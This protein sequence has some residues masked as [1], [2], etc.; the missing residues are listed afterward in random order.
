M[1]AQNYR[2]STDCKELIGYFLRYARIKLNKMTEYLT[3][4]EIKQR[5]PNEWV[6][7]GDPKTDGLDV[8]GGLVLYHSKDKKEVCYLGRDQ[9]KPFAMSTLIFAGDLKPMRKLGILKRL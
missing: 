4:N 9:I 3:L 1:K 5:F 7:L 8:L 6:L 2:N